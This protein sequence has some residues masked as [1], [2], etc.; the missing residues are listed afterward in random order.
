ML[1]DSIEEKIAIDK[2]IP[3]CLK[4]LATLFE[5]VNSDPWKFEAA[6]MLC[7]YTDNWHTNT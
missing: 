1:L 6:K 3:T 7:F 2:I 5:S 4:T